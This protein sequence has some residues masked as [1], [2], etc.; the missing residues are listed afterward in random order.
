MLHYALLNSIYYIK[1]AFKF[2]KNNLPKSKC[3]YKPDFFA[4]IIYEETALMTFLVKLASVPRNVIPPLEFKWLTAGISHVP[5]YQYLPNFQ[6]L[7]PLTI[8]FC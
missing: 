3:T 6:I 4:R 5:L 8:L 2:I 1:S 7:C